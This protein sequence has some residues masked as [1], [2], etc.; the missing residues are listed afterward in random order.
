MIERLRSSPVVSAV[1]ALGLAYFAILSFMNSVGRPITPWTFTGLEDHAPFINVMAQAFVWSAVGLIFSAMLTH[2]A[3]IYIMP[4]AD[5]VPAISRWLARLTQLLWWVVS[6]LALGMVG[7]YAVNGELAKLFDLV[8]LGPVV[9]LALYQC[10]IDVGLIR[11][12][13]PQ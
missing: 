3:T 10:A 1:V 13:V 8:L 2:L 9:P 11:F 5:G 12:R 4:F 6:I 7:T